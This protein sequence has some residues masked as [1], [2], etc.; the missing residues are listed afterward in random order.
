MNFV[1]NVTR[2]LS[3]LQWWNRGTFHIPFEDY[4]SIS[5]AAYLRSCAQPN[6]AVFANSNCDMLFVMDPTVN[7]WDIEIVTQTREAA[8]RK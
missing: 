4:Y 7:G 2:Q 3:P 5:A 8:K 6:D 1:P